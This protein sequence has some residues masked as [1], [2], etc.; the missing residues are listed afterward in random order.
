[1]SFVSTRKRGPALAEQRDILCRFPVI[2]GH[3]G[4]RPDGR[5]VLTH[6]E[7]NRRDRFS[8]L[9][10]FCRS[11]K[12]AQM[13]VKLL[14]CLLWLLLLAPPIALAQSPGSVFVDEL[15]WT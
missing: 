2:S 6:I 3:A 12:M 10:D 7:Q 14:R 9:D 13:M 1:M 5:G 11:P 4:D 8:N 15:T